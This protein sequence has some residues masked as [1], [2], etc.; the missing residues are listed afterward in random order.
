MQ[1]VELIVQPSKVEGIPRG[2]EALYLNKKILLP[3]CVPEFKK[4]IHFSLKKLFVQ[5]NCKRILKILESS[6]KPHYDLSL[7]SVGI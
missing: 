4:I 7:H 6:K 5:K 3:S 1:F 2:V